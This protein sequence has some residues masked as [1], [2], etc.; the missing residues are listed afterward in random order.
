MVEK[1]NRFRRKGAPTYKRVKNRK[2]A[3]KI[4]CSI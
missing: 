4:S 2:G 1:E 3:P